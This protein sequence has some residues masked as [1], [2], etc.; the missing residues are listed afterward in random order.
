V[1][2]LGTGLTKRACEAEAA[3]PLG[4]ERL[5]FRP[6]FLGSA[7]SRV[8]ATTTLWKLLGVSSRSPFGAVD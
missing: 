4:T 7:K 1:L 2:F 5:H 8:V 3:T 6:L